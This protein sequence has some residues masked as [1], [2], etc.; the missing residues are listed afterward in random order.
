MPKANVV[1]E[2]EKM[3]QKREERRQK[4]EEIKR[5][6]AEK[7]AEVALLGRN[8]DVD[9]ELM[10]KK[11][12]FNT[13]MLQPHTPA[14]QLKLCVCVRKRPVF[15]KEETGGE[16]DAVSCANPQIVV[17]DC[18]LKVD[19]ITKYVE[20]YNFSFDNTFNEK[21]SNEDVYNFSVKPLGEHLFNQ[22][23]VT[24]FAYGQ[25]GSGKTFT[26]VI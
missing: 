15:K 26:M 10:I 7:Q 6:K 16:I 5:E 12:R 4:I 14:S 8:I 25:T 13:D 1:Y 24:C 19:G 17:H 21:E 3:N 9:F 20:N 2:I 23:L 11:N 18:K 22:G